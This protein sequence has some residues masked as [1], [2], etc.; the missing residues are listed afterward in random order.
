MGA[1]GDFYSVWLQACWRHAVCRMTAVTPVTPLWTWATGL[2]TGQRRDAQRCAGALRRERPTGADG[3]HERV[4]H[5]RQ[6]PS[7]DGLPGGGGRAA[8]DA[9]LGPSL[10]CQDLH[11]QL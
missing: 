8:F 10:A 2:A 5:E 7:G 11:A 1:F 4:H 3:R 9:S 6:H